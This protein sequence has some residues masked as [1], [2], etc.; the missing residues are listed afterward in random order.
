MCRASFAPSSNPSIES[1][2][3]CVRRSRA[4]PFAA[5]HPRARW[6]PA[7][8]RARARCSTRANAS[9]RSPAS[10]ATRA[11]TGR[12]ATDGTSSRTSSSSART[13]PR[14]RARGRRR[15]CSRACARGRERAAW[16]RCECCASGRTCAWARRTS[17]GG[18]T[19]RAR[20]RG[21]RR[22]CGWS[23]ERDCITR[24]RSRERRTWRSR[25]TREC[26][27]TIRAIGIRR[28]NEWWCE[29]ER[30]SC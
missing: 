13:A 4:A 25:L 15:R 28:S 17:W 7:R 12:R 2:D 9:E 16:T 11:R 19:T 14:G 29:S 6:T 27:G 8:R 22:R 23:F 20:G 5:A 1:I 26:G 24:K 10:R 18:S 3:R 30:R 21:T